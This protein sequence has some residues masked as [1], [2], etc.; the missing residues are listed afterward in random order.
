MDKK[1]I[2]SLI[3]FLMTLTCGAFVQIDSGRF[4]D[5]G[6]GLTIL[7]V[8]LN[9]EDC[10]KDMFKAVR[11]WRFNAVRIE[12]KAVE[13]LPLLFKWAKKYDLYLQLSIDA[14]IDINELKPFIKRK[15]LLAWEVE[16]LQQAQKLN[17]L[18]ENHL[19]AISV[20]NGTKPQNALKQEEHA[21]I[22]DFITLN[23]LP[24][25]FGWVAPT[26]LHFGLKHAFL[27]TT[28][29]L[30][31]LGRMAKQL[32]KPMVVTSCAYPRNK[33]FRF[34]GSETNNRE[35][36]F[37]TVQSF[38]NQ[39]SDSDVKIAA[40]FFSQWRLND[41]AMTNE[42]PQPDASYSIYPSDNNFLNIAR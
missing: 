8:N 34:E 5:N 20:T 7:G 6:K 23:L 16:T 26:N 28:M 30:N 3:M 35:A 13:H 38:M 11:A 31:E 17:A 18:D 1:I 22:I 37:A 42:M 15:E 19:I 10:T 25:D 24:I 27:K 40:C 39:Q 9:P 36:Y 32:N 14:N 21:P 4:S 33:M 2:L 41:S 29:L 12:V